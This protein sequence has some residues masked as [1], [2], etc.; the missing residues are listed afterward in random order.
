MDSQD[1]NSLLDNIKKL[2]I[3]EQEMYSQLQQ[4]HNQSCITSESVEDFE[5][6]PSN[7]LR[8]KNNQLLNNK[9]KRLVNYDNVNKCLLDCKNN[10][11][12]KSFSY[13][14]NTYTGNCMLCKDNIDSSM[15][16]TWKTLKG[17]TTRTYN[18]V[19]KKNNTVD[20][21]CSEN[22]VA[23]QNEILKKINKISNV[24]LDLFKKIQ[25]RYDNVS[26]N[27]ETDKDNLKS[28]IAMVNVVEDQINQLKSN[29]KAMKQDKNNRLR[30]IQ[31]GNYEYRRYEKLKEMMRILFFACLII[32]LVSVALQRG[33]LPS[34]LSSGI[35]FIVFI[36]STIMVFYKGYDLSFRRTDDFDKY[37]FYNME[38]AMNDEDS[39]GSSD[40]I[41]THDKEFFEKLIEDTDKNIQSLEK[42]AMSSMKHGYKK[43]KDYGKKVSNKKPKKQNVIK[44]S[45]D[46]KGDKPNVVEGF[47]GFNSL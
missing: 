3:L 40:S 7:N 2:Q 12:C 1:N 6:S 24:R 15:D 32:A 27:L 17:I 8:C 37:D 29:I 21:K 19:M 30:M 5:E 18:K 22:I 20:S 11:D 42:S 14:T 16:S 39:M 23:K 35:I 10:K 43:A 46:I 36:V 33:L 4:L 41:F 38:N 9:G 25:Q 34:G 31:I 44:V 45:V 13:Y 28:Q 26:E 47:S